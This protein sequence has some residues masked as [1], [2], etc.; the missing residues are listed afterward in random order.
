MGTMSIC[1]VSPLGVSTCDIYGLT[2]S[3]DCPNATWNALISVWKNENYKSVKLIN[4]CGTLPSKCPL[5]L[6]VRTMKVK[7]FPTGIP[8]SWND[9]NSSLRTSPV[10]GAMNTWDYWFIDPPLLQY[11]S[12]RTLKGESGIWAS[13]YLTEITYSPGCVTL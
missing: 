13:L 5:A 6:W 11:P 3:W 1:S 12:Y 9:A 7:A 8:E 10:A 2:R 4:E